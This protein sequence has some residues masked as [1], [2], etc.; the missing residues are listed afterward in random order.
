MLNYKGHPCS[1]K[2]FAF[3]PFLHNILFIQ[4]ILE[5]HSVFESNTAVSEKHHRERVTDGV[6]ELK[7][8]KI[9]DAGGWKPSDSF[10]EVMNH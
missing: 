10:S 2:N 7:Q 3:G 8:K 6:K 5:S 4:C 9:C 1:P